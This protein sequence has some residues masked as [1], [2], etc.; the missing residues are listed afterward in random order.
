MKIA[1]LSMPDVAPLILHEE[2]IHMPNLGIA[3]VGANIDEGHEV[4]VIDLIRKRRN[5]GK[6]LDR[7]LGR[8]RPDLVGLS[9]MAWQYDTCLRIARRIKRLLPGVRIAL[10][11]YHATLMHREIAA[12]PEAGLIDFLI[13]GEGEAACR[14]LVNALEGKDDLAAIPSLSY[15]ADG[16]F[17]H[18]ERAE[19]CDLSRIKLPIRD[20][21]R[22]TRGYHQLAGRIEVIETSRGCTRNCNFCSIRHMYGRNFRP[23]PVERVLAD[24]DVIYHRNKTRWV[25]VSDDNLVLDPDRVLVLC[26]AILE[27]GYPGLHFVIQAD[28]LTMSRHPDMIRRMAQAGF[29]SVFLGIENV[30]PENLAMARKGN[31]VEASRRAVKLCHENGMMVVGGLVLGFPGDDEEALIRNFEFFRELKVDAAYC[32]FLTPYPKTGIRADLM[33]AGLVTNPDDYRWYNGMWA[34]VRTRHLDAERLQYLFWY[35]KQRVLGWWEPSDRMRRGGRLWTG[36]WRFA[37]R[38]AARYFFDR[39]L[40]KIGWE[41][42][43]REDMERQRGINRFPDLED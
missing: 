9:A 27:R 39:K 16:R 38:P 18:N 32:Q 37:F 26:D 20:E 35:H 15:K 23:F 22:L 12:G 6:Y 4:V 30:S 14:R 3:S 25:F 13:R 33:E 28:C 40:R 31:I 11:G 24:L 41:G 10:G 5:P 17:V 19:P 29:R 2:A 21:R 42:M 43:Y 36:I 7:T 8:F 34:N 1:L